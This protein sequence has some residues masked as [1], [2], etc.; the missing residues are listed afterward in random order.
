M[1]LK[2]RSICFILLGIVLAYTAFVLLD[3]RT[4]IYSLTYL[5]QRDN[6]TILT[7]NAPTSI[8][9]LTIV[10]TNPSIG[11]ILILVLEIDGKETPDPSPKQR[12]KEKDQL[13]LGND[14]YIVKDIYLTGIGFQTKVLIKKR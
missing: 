14:T 1:T 2:K 5:S 11:S 13:K 10:A 4:F 8:D 7:Q 3:I 12:L 9:D 6:I